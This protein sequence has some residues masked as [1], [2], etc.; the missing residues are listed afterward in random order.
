MLKVVTFDIFRASQTALKPAISE[1][2]PSPAVRRGRVSLSIDLDAWHFNHFRD[3]GHLLIYSQRTPE[4]REVPVMPWFRSRISVCACSLFL[5]TNAAM[6]IRSAG[7][8]SCS[9]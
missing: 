9:E 1:S 5:I 8:S 4:F 2:T 7:S 3:I 6:S